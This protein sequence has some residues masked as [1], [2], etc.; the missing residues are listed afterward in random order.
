MEIVL[1]INNDAFFSFLLGA[2][3]G[4]LLEHYCKS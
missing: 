1:P 3:V 2:V 4:Q